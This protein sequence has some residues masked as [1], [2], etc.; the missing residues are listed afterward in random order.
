MERRA[1]IAEETEI[2]IYI[3]IKEE[4]KKCLIFGLQARL[5][6]GII[7]SFFGYSNE[8]F[9]LMQTL[10]HSTRAFIFNAK[11]LNGFLVN[12][13]LCE[14]LNDAKKSGQLQKAFSHQ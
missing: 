1:R 6:I 4:L 12:L 9:E 13:D 5:P 8:V 10:S 3:P 11:G 7:L 2:D 14:I